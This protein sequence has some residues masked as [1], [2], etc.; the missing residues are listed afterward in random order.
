ME[1]QLEE[2]NQELQRVGDQG[3]VRVPALLGAVGAGW[4]RWRLPTPVPS[5]GMRRAYVACGVSATSLLVGA[6]ATRA[7]LCQHRRQGKARC[8]W[9]GPQRADGYPCPR[10]LPAA[11]ACQGAAPGTNGRCWPGVPPEAR[12]RHIG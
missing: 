8:L 7:V 5:P 10:R 6:P 12:V 4:R 2:K 3:A 1:A 11:L 9:A